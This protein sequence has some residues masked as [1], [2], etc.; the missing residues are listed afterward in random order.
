MIIKPLGDRILV[1]RIEQKE[2]SIGGLYI[3]DTAQEKPMEGVVVAVGTG[4]YNDKGE[5]NTFYVKEG[6][7]V[8]FG[9]WSGDDIVIED[10]EY[11]IITEDNI[12]GI[13]K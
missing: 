13:L 4:T 5:R 1:K 3:P 12:I 9:K 7:R 2:K 10:E 6:D 8:V 11:V